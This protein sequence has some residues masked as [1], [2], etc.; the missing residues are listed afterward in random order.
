MAPAEPNQALASSLRAAGGASCVVPTDRIWLVG[1]NHKTGTLLNKLILQRTAVPF[2]VQEDEGSGLE[3]IER[4]KGGEA[5]LNRHVHIGAGAE[6]QRMRQAARRNGAE[7]RMVHWIRDPVRMTIS[8]YLYDRRGV[9]MF[10]TSPILPE[11]RV[12]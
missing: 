5:C 2:Q 10:A 11:V 3:C 6:W 4:A 9:W 1:T 7:L 8:S 12:L